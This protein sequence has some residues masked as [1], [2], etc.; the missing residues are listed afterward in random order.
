MSYLSCRIDPP[1]PPLIRG[2]LEV[3]TLFLSRVELLIG[4]A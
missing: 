4:K 2:E 3:E 1:Q